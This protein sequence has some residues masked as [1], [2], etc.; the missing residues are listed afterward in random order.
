MSDEQRRSGIGG[1]G[2]GI[3]TGIGILN[4]FREA[5]EETFQEAVTRGDLSPERARRFMDEAAERLQATLDGARE[6]LE[7]VPRRD[8]DELRAELERLRERVERLEERAGPGTS[9]IIITS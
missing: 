1:I 2:D 7:M 6:R 9:D 3:R 4:A 8:V 5:I